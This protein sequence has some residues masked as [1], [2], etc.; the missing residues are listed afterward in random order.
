MIHRGAPVSLT[1]D[2]FPGRVFTARVSRLAGGVDPQTRTLPV[3]IDIDNPGHVLRPGM[4]A[5]ATVNAGSQRA[6]VVPLTAIV[7]VG[8]ENYVWAVAD[9]RT[10][11]RQVT[12]GRETG[13]IVE[14][15]SGLTTADTIVFRGSDQVRE[16]QVV[17]TQQ[18]GL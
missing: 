15:T 2:A 3:E 5:T 1:V 6:L 11:Q 4:Y 18:V 8:T 13:A 9:G 14:I 16:G 17:K 10:T 12:V 7:T